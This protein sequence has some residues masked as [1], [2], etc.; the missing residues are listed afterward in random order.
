[1]SSKK[2]AD[3][4]SNSQCAGL[5]R[6]VR[7]RILPETL[8]QDIFHSQHLSP[9]RCID[10]S[11]KILVHGSNRPCSSCLCFCV[12]QPQSI[13]NHSYENVFSLY[14]RFG[15]NQNHFHINSFA[16]KLVLK[17]RQMTTRKWLI[18]MYIQ[19]VQTAEVVLI[20]IYQQEHEI[21]C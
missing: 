5:S 12:S 3:F 8:G 20:E 6:T 9:P 10:R 4:L 19:V 2:S 7:D 13:R 1:M 14:V 16:G 18:S 21:F 17:P 11:G 15:A